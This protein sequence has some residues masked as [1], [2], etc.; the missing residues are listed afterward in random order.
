MALGPL[1]LLN[2]TRATFRLCPEVVLISSFSSE[3][4][5][6]AYKCHFWYSQEMEGQKQVFWGLHRPLADTPCLYRPHNL[7]TP[8]VV[9]R[10]RTRW[11][12]WDPW[13]QN[14]QKIRTTCIYFSNSLIVQMFIN[15]RQKIIFCQLYC[16]L[17]IC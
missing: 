3:C 16:Y 1:K 5:L 11:T 12:L 7:T 6:K 10:L 13:V 15:G 2:A 17:Y 14:L 4:L 8:P 9:F